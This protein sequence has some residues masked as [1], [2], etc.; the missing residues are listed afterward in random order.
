LALLALAPTSCGGGDDELPIYAG[1]GAVSASRFRLPDGFEAR[2]S[3]ATE[4]VGPGELAEELLLRGSVR[5]DGNRLASVVARQE[6]LV[7]EVHAELGEEVREGQLLAVLE[8]RALARARSGYVEASHRVEF[9]ERAYER[10]EQLWLKRISSEDEYLR[11]KHALE[12]ARLDLLTAAQELRALGLRADEL[13][14]LV[15]A[16]TTG[17]DEVAADLTRFE[18]RAPISGSIVARSA[19]LGQAVTP[20]ATL[21]EVADLGAVWI[22]LRVPAAELGGV[23]VGLP[24]AVESRELGISA[25]AE[26]GYVDP[27]VD[28]D[29]QTV[30]VRIVLPNE[31]GVWRPGLFVTV[32]A[33]LPGRA[34]EIVAPNEALHRVGGAVVAFVSLGRGEWEARELEVGEDDGARVEIL[35][36]LRPGER[37]ATTD[38]QLLKAAWLGQGGEEE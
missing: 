25:P 12:E 35:S 4:T 24:V 26:I 30:L 10:E 18:L 1:S 15:E 27:R 21:F 6:G 19:V 37:V 17:G 31:D 28:A 3:L 8:S 9:A 32:R 34:C 11:A 36:G 7:Q 29:T 16:S 14:G 2:T 5:F 23:E 20:D 38:A 22:D 13:S 33:K